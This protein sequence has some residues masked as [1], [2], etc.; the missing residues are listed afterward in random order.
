[1]RSVVVAI[2]GLVLTAGPAFAQA[3]STSPS[4]VVAPTVKASPSWTIYMAYLTVGIAA[5]TLLLAW[6]G[7]MVQAP[8]FRR[9]QRAQAGQAG[10]GQA[11]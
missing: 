9:G 5:L 7:Y 10:S 2:V 11:S 8:G 3:P 4:P 1:M 6:L